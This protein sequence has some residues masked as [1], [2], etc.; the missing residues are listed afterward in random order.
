MKKQ[1]CSTVTGKIAFIVILQ[2]TIKTLILQSIEI[3]Q[4]V[5]FDIHFD[6]SCQT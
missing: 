5:R 2:N 3:K 6:M 1:K 4:T